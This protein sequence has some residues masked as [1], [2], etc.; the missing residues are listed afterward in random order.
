M[1]PLKLTSK[2]TFLLL[3]LVAVAQSQ[4]LEV[5]VGGTRSP[6]DAFAAAD[7]AVR[8]LN[9]N[10][11][12]LTRYQRK[13][14]AKS[15]RYFYQQPISFPATV[16]LKANGQRLPASGGATR[17]GGGGLTLIFDASGPNAFSAE[18]Q[19]YLQDVYTR[20][21]PF[22]DILF[23]TPSV[24][25]NVDV[26]N[27]DATMGDRDIVSGGYYVPN[28]PGTPQIRFPVY[29]PVTGDNS[30]AEVV[31][32][33]FIHTLLLAY[34]GPNQY[35]FDAFNEGIVRA[36]TMRI[37]RTPSAMP[38]GLSTDKIEQV[39]ANTYDVEGHYDWYNQRALGGAKFIAPNLRDVPLPDAGSVGGLY[40]LRYKMAGA[41][42][43]KSLIEKADRQFIRRFNEAFYAQPGIANDVNALVALGQSVLNTHYSGDPTIEGLSFAEWFRRQYI[44]ET[45]NT[46]GPKLLVEPVPITS[47]LSGNDYGVYI[48]QANWFET[49][50][51]G[52]E[53]LL[54]GTSYPIIW[55]GNLAFNRTFP[56]TPDAEKMDIAGGYGS[57]VPNITNLYNQPYRAAIDV[58]VQDQLERVYVP[59]GAIANASQSTPRDF[60]GTVAGANLQTGDVL[61][62][63]V[64]ING[65][66]IS[67]VPV[68]RNA[69][70]ALINTPGYLG[71][72]NIVIN[73]VRNRQGADTTL[74]TRKVNKGPGPLALDLRIDS[75]DTLILPGGL[76]KGISLIGF[77]ID[78]FASLNSIVLGLSENQVLAA[79][80]NSSKA[81]YDLYPE[82]EAFKVGHG[83]FL[84]LDSAQPGF[85]V[86]GRIYTNVEASVAL[87]PGWNLV[88]TPL[89]ETV[90]TNRIRVVKASDS[91]LNWADASAEIGTEFFE[92]IPGPP[93]A[94]TGAPET[95]TMAPATQFEPGKAY[96]VRVLAAEGVTL[97]F[98]PDDFTGAR[99]QSASIVPSPTGWKM[100]LTL[101]YGRTDLK[102][103]AIIGQSTTATRAFDSREDTGM[104]PSFGKG[105]QVIV[106]DYEPMYR[107]IRAIGGEV[108]TLHFQGLTP[109]RTYL[110][111]LQQLFGTVPSLSIRDANG[112]SLGTIRP[113]M[114][115]GF[116]ARSRDGYIQI[117][118]AG[119]SR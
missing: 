45:R 43:T 39:L 62:L 118:A 60:Y 111:D 89:M 21:Q 54:S 14:L 103:S 49:L 104:P 22:L 110:L 16:W 74:L 25:G 57:V 26:K 69:F 4:T 44:L 99:P 48:I 23:G 50:A 11:A 117:V 119:G 8:R 77:P 88:T 9:A 91:P 30:R 24:S 27:Y 34:I 55:E 36:I 94:A 81:K 33:N 90:T 96:F 46:R 7:G 64:T 66:P 102:A 61:R 20:A 37:A 70:G 87:K 41:A 53:T 10:I 40:L 75:E 35:G 73:V 95:G 71:D 76:P 6:S 29:G 47:G 106:E 63:Q 56:S 97:S 113:G 31:A 67:D 68:T 82:L 79:R 116:Y 98:Q 114:T 72:A 58:P 3:A 84:R 80:Y 86:P 28:S 101:R 2:L 15:G 78:P 112:R 51:G 18:Y 65:T 109:F 5:E 52:N 115:F 85:Q 92:F 93:D 100:R 108:Y 12:N 1:I 59:V 38:L 83:Y 105:F 13:T 19:A 42:W 107:D 32:V 17:G